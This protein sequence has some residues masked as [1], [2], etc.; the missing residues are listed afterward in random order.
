VLNSQHF[1]IEQNYSTL[2]DRSTG[3]LYYLSGLTASQTSSWS[4][5]KPG[6]V[7]GNGS[8][9]TITKWTGTSSVGNSSITDDGNTVTI[10][11]NFNVLGTSST[12]NTKNLVVKDPIILL[13]ATQSGSPCRLG[14]F[15]NRGTGAT[16]GFI[17]D[18]SGQEFAF[19]QTPDASD[20]NVNI[21][22]YSKA[23]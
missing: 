10:N 3:D 13:A 9:N 6:T 15:I 7:V 16:Q 2:I 5:I 17:W 1:Q 14:I 8:L 19:I 23:K 21:A 11:A 4:I 20:V 22:T 18:E 12:I